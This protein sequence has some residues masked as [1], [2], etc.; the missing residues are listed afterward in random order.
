[1]KQDIHEKFRDILYSTMKSDKVVALS[2][3]Y[4]PIRIGCNPMLAANINKK[5]ECIEFLIAALK[6]Y[7]APIEHKKKIIWNYKSYINTKLKPGKKIQLILSKETEKKFNNIKKGNRFGKPLT[8]DRAF[9]IL[10]N[11]N[12]QHLI[13]Y[14][15]KIKSQKETKNKTNTI[16][17]ESKH[18]EE[19]FKKYKYDQKIKTLE[20]SIRAIERIQS[21][22][23]EA[24]K[25]I[26]IEK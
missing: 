25:N 22:I 16:D 11:E 20:D 23:L 6:N 3:Q 5:T 7:A 14:N 19:F 8:N 26:K 21:E 4:L 18:G 17:R 24:I 10:V 12:Y 13:N 1:M 2:M 9:E 15:E